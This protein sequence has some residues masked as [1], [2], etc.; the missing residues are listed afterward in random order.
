MRRGV[1]RILLFL[2]LAA[3]VA[4]G[5]YRMVGGIGGL[6]SFTLPDFPDLPPPQTELRAGQSGTIYFES[7]TPFDLDVLIGDVRLARPT[8]AV[9]TLS[10]PER[11]PATTPVPAMVI[12]HG[13][14]GITPGREPEYAKLLTRAGIAAFVID[15][16]LPRGA[17]QDVN[18]MIRVLSITEF[19][20]IT[21]A[22][23]ALRLLQTDPDIDPNRIGIVGFSYG[24]MAARFSMDD[25]IERALAPRAPPFALHVDYYGPCFQ[26]LNGTAITGAPLLTL[27]GTAD[28]SNDL[29]ACARREDELRALGADIETVVFEGAGHAWEARI[30]RKLHTDAPYVS[31]CE[32]DYDERGHSFSDGAGIVDVPIETPRVARG[33]LATE[34]AEIRTA[35][36][37]DRA[38]FD[39][40]EETAAS[41]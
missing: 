18:Y 38:M 6:V 5:A 27:R 9:G 25:R 12:V 39:L 3:G 17:T 22:Y 8:T 2:L 13:S 21:D 31:G 41:G 15:Y 23:A 4:Y 19:D 33:D 11:T 7:A 28:A 14:G 35:R 16:Y 32:V 29:M 20:A 26:N 1:T 40:G 24:G 36:P 37:I 10:L 34:R 30:P